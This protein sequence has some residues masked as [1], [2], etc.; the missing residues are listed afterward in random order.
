MISKHVY[1]LHIRQAWRREMDFRIANG[2][3]C[4]KQLEGAE[5]EEWVSSCLVD[6]CF[7]SPHH[8]SCSQRHLQ[9]TIELSQRPQAQLSQT[10]D[11]R[12]KSPQLLLVT[13]ME[14]PLPWSRWSGFELLSIQGDF[15]M[16]SLKY[17]LNQKINVIIQSK[18]VCLLD[19]SLIWKLNYIKQ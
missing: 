9:A 8:A 19:F 13:I 7:C 2:V 3:I 14:S 10:H 16:L 18:H 5:F 12:V 6:W 17:D 11:F 15:S 1:L 4:T